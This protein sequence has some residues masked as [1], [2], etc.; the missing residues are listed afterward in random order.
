MLLK[1]INPIY[2]NPHIIQIVDAF[3]ANNLD[4][5]GQPRKD[6]IM[7][8]HGDENSNLAVSVEGLSYV[9]LNEL[10]N[11]LYENGKVDISATVDAKVEVCPMDIIE[12]LQDTLTDLD[13]WTVSDMDD[14]EDF[15]FDDLT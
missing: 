12:S 7:V 15:D 5:N 6:F 1:F 14:F 10:M 9:K 3:I 8:L 2:N 4:E 11:E 13:D